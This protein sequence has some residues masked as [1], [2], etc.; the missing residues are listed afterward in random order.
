MDQTLVAIA[1]YALAALLV[2]FFMAVEFARSPASAARYQAISYRRKAF[3][4]LIF[5]P[6]FSAFPVLSFMSGY[7]VLAALF[8]LFVP[9]ALMWFKSPGEQPATLA[10]A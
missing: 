2:Y 10:Q 6:S 7:R 8:A 9:L 3:F 5:V 4:W 1:A